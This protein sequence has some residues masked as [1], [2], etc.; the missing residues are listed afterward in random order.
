MSERRIISSI[1]RFMMPQSDDPNTSSYMRP[2]LGVTTQEAIE[3]LMCAFGP[4]TPD[5]IR[6][7]SDGIAPCGYEEL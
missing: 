2:M 6:E 1:E 5:P 4:W 7:S 3:A